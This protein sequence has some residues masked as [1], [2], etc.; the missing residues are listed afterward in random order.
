M[1]YT[2]RIIEGGV[3]ALRESDDTNFLKPNGQSRKPQ[4]LCHGRIY[5]MLHTLVACLKLSSRSSTLT[6][7]RS[8][9][10]S[11]VDM[12]EVWVIESVLGR[13]TTVWLIYQHFL[14]SRRTGYKLTT[15]FFKIQTFEVS[16]LVVIRRRSK[17]SAH[18]LFSYIY[19]CFFYQQ[20]QIKKSE[21]PTI[22]GIAIHILI[23]MNYTWEL[24]IKND[25]AGQLIGID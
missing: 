13:Y 12:I 14:Q 22:N 25:E 4:C 5:T 20:N 19:M 10:P 23:K 8:H 11:G 3:G 21:A 6:S 24:R 17:S 7:T 9:S 16:L 18:D 15:F 1:C 2:R